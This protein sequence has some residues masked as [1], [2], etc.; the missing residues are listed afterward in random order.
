MEIFFNEKEQSFLSNI[1]NINL[2]EILLRMSIVERIFEIDEYSDQIVNIVKE[3]NIDEYHKIIFDNASNYIR[4]HNYSEMYLNSFKYYYNCQ[5]REFDELSSVRGHKEDSFRIYKEHLLSW[6]CSLI[7]LL[8]S[9]ISKNEDPG[10]KKIVAVFESC[11][12]NK[13]PM[14]MLLEVKKI[15][16]SLL[17]SAYYYPYVT[18]S[19]NKRMFKLVLQEYLPEILHFVCHGEE[20]GDLVFF[21]GNYTGVKCFSP[22]YLE[23]IICMYGS[24]QM[25][26]IYLNSCYSKKFVKKI[27]VNNCKNYILYHLG[28]EGENNDRQAIKFSEEFYT[29]L[30]VHNQTIDHT[31]NDVYNNFPNVIVSCEGSKINYKDNLFFA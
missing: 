15:R 27:L 3:S 24:K 25:E 11:Q 20:N 31:F 28:Y 13:H 10:N 12:A 30:A 29:N 6:E 1:L 4:A 18:L 17:S 22:E 2:S 23:K 5:R 8:L 14:G 19:T 21:N 9:L 7:N 16:D 26:F